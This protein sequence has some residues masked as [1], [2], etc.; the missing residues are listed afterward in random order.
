M[1]NE[2]N[3]NCEEKSGEEKT[4][5]E[6]IKYKFFME[7]LNKYSL[8]YINNYNEDESDKYLNDLLNNFEKIKAETLE[9]NSCCESIESINSYCN[10]EEYTLKELVV[11]CEYY[12]IKINKI[13]KNN[14]IEL[15]EDFE[16]KSENRSIVKKRKTNWNYLNVLKNDK[17]LKKYILGF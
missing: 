2:K 11:I 7:D 6:N 12:N 5:E 10:Y 3:I 9:I 8:D 17:I 13:K 16:N 4:N 14:I 1:L 15:I